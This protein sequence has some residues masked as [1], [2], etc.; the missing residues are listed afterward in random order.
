ME[1]QQL[2]SPYQGNNCPRQ[3]LPAW[4]YRLLALTVQEDREVYPADFDEDLS[5]FEE[6]RDDSE[7]DPM[8]TECECD[9]EDSGCGCPPPDDEDMGRI[10]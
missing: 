4:Y 8:G 10:T 6:S 9:S 7:M 1:R 5:V 3:E 2:K